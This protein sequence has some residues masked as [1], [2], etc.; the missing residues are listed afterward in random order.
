MSKT[1]ESDKELGLRTLKSGFPK[2]ELR[3]N[4]L[5]KHYNGDLDMAIAD[6]R[7]SFVSKVASSCITRDNEVNQTITDK[8]DKI[9][10]HRSCV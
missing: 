9:V 6:V 5:N 4:A 7:Y 1:G 2:A 3:I 8:I 10:L